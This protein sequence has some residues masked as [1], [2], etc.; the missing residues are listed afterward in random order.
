MQEEEVRPGPHHGLQ[1]GVEA[2][3][4]TVELGSGLSGA[5]VYAHSPRMVLER[6][7]EG[8]QAIFA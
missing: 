3:L 4:I 7:P 1:L 8:T 6:D 5:G 2:L